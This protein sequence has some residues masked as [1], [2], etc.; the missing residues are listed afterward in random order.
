MTQNTVHNEMNVRGNERYNN[1]KTKER[2][3]MLK[4][5]SV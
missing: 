4:A 5:E 3:A 1:A 2:K